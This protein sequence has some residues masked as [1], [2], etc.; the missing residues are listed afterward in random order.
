MNIEPII[1]HFKYQ[2]FVII[3][4]KDNGL[5]T[6][7]ISELNDYVDGLQVKRHIPFSTTPWGWGNLLDKGP[8]KQ[9]TENKV[10]NLFCK[11]LFNS[12]DYVFPNMMINSMF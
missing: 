12:D 11:N 7:I 2:G 9:I 5:N 1:Q 4:S 6:D 8:F 3:P 10:L